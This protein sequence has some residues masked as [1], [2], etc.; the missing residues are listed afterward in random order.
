MSAS[1]SIRSLFKRCEPASTEA[2]ADFSL[3]VRAGEFV[4][5]LGPSG[6][7]KTTILKV[8]AGFERPTAGDIFIGVNAGLTNGLGLIGD[9][10]E[11]AVTWDKWPDF[12]AEVRTRIGAVLKEVVGEAHSLSCR[13]THIYTDGPAPYYTSSDSQN[14]SLPKSDR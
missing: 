6:S 1:I 7:G 8:I 4:T 11:T 13:F 3:E 10:F 12:D 5:L 2:V 14:S 9:T